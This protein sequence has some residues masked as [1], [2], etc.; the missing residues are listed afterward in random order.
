MYAVFHWFSGIASVGY[1]THLYTSFLFV[2][3]WQKPEERIVAETTHQDGNATCLED[4]VRLLSKVGLKI[5]W[6][7]KRYYKLSVWLIIALCELFILKENNFKKKYYI[8]IQFVVFKYFILH[9]CL[10]LFYFSSLARNFVQS[11]WRLVLS[12]IYS[13]EEKVHTNVQGNSFF[14]L[15]CPYYLEDWMRCEECKKC[16][17]SDMIYKNSCMVHNTC[18]PCSQYRDLFFRCMFYCRRPHEDYSR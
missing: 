13:Y 15:G 3:F 17:E 11:C 18:L 1:N 9:H 2:K 6:R 5:V 12:L 14:V 7:N 8:I 10:N 4:L 16:N